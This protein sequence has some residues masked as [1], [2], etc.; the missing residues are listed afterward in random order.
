MTGPGHV[1]LPSSLLLL[2]HSRHSAQPGLG[3]VAAAGPPS[4]PSQR[5]ASSS[6]SS[7]AAA[8]AAAAATEA[9]LDAPTAAH[10]HAFLAGPDP[11]AAAAAAEGLFAAA[12]QSRELT[13]RLAAHRELLY[14]LRQV[15]RPEAGRGAGA[16]G[17]RLQAAAAYLA[18]AVAGTSATADAALVD[19]GLV[20]GLVALLGATR[21]GEAKRG[22]ARAISR[23]LGCPEAVEQLGACG[24]LAA[25]AALL[26]SHDC[27]GWVGGWVRGGSGLWARD[28]RADKK[29]DSFAGN[30]ICTV[31][32]AS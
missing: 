26:D 12:A 18:S 10:L 2:A 24:G 8:L 11:E 31:M 9:G 32:P 29:L 27:G 25:V 1:A 23:L 28:E 17:E 5:S 4:V 22:A 6:Q 19:H 3:A 13:A 7:G 20:G 21:C 15:L 30:H 16:A 14:R